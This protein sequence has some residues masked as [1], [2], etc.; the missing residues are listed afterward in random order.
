MWP[1]LWSWPTLGTPRDPRET[2]G[3]PPWALLA[4]TGSISDRASDIQECERL[5]RRWFSVVEQ[6]DF[7]RLGDLVHEEVLLVSKVRPGLVV[8]GKES[9]MRFT[10][11]TLADSL[12]EASTTSFHAL[13]DRRIVVEGRVRW[14]DDERVIRDDPVTWA[15]EFDDGLLARF[16]PARTRIE[17]E[18]LL[19]TPS[20]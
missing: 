11:D 10:R 1:L 3:D 5:A 14:I 13:D 15:M 16:I 4:H 8:E 2:W 17:A 12:Y 18:T 20:S 19:G 7:E 9:F 6:R